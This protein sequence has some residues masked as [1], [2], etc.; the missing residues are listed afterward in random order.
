M[1]FRIISGIIIILIAC[2]SNSTDN[3]ISNNIDPKANDTTEIDWSKSELNC[4]KLNEKVVEFIKKPSDH[5]I[6][7]IINFLRKSE[8]NCQ[9][10]SEFITRKIVATYPDNGRYDNCVDEDH[11]KLFLAL[12]EFYQ[13]AYLEDLIILIGCNA[14]RYPKTFDSFLSTLDKKLNLSSIDFVSFA[15]CVN[16]D[17]KMG[18]ILYLDNLEKNKTVFS[19]P[20]YLSKQYIQVYLAEIDRKL[21]ETKEEI[22]YSV[23]L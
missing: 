17:S 7:E 19:T 5:S 18:L 15:C 16:L 8:I 4:S 3:T 1:D 12:V 9:S 2:E 21:L 6:S 13:G 11:F 10:D 23:E 14:Y 22:K 20:P